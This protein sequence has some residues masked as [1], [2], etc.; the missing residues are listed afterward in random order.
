[1]P[2]SDLNRAG[3]GPTTDRHRILVEWNETVRPAPPATWPDLFAAQVRR[4]PGAVAVVCEDV[5]LTYAQLDARANRLAHALLAR[6]VGPERVVALCLPRSVDMIVAEV[7]VLKAGGAYLPVDQDY[8]AERTGFMLADARPV[9][10]VSTTALASELPATPG[11]PRLLLD[12]LLADEPLAD[13][14]PPTDDRA[15]TR[16]AGTDQAEIDR[17]GGRL[18]DTDP[19]DDDRGA[20]LTPD[21]AAYVI[22]TSGSTG[23]PKGVVVSHAGVAKLVATQRARLGVGPQSRVLQFASPSFDVAFWDLCLGLLSGGRLVVVPAERRVPGPA[24]TEYAHRHGVTFMILPP[25]LLAAMP[26]ELT[27]PAGATLLAGTE[28]V[29]PE[30]VARWARDRPMFNAYG[31]T[32]ATVN[33]TLGECD[34]QT[35]PGGVVPI[36]RPDP[37]TRCYVLD[38]ALQPV[39][40]GA[41]G[42]LYLGGTGL[43][44]GYLG[45]PGLTAQRFVADPYGPAGGRL[46]RTGDLVR[47]LPDGRL[48]FLGRADDQVKIRGYRIE[49]GEI[50]SVLAQHPAVGQVAVLARPGR[51]GQQRLAAYVVPALDRPADR[52]AGVESARV[53]DW[54]RLHELLYTA[55][56]TERFGENFTGWNSSYD[57][58]PIPLAEMREWRDR[59]VERILALR[60]RRVLELGVG[61]GLLLAK[62]APEVESYW[63]TDLSPAAIEALRDEVAAVPALAGRVELRAQPADVTDGLPTGFFDTIVLNSVLQYFPSVDYLAD[64]LRRAV[65]LLAP[66]GSVFVGD[67]RNLRLHRTLRGAIEAGRRRPDADGRPAA[68]AAVEQALSWEGELLLDPEFFPALARE[69]PAIA[70][71]DVEVKRGRAHNELTRYRYDVVL[72]TAATDPST[73]DEA[74]ERPWHDE[75]A[76]LTGLADRLDSARPAV[77]RVTGVPNARLDADLTAYRNL[78]GAP[79]PTAENGAAGAPG[80]DPEAVYELAGRHGYRV[81]VTWS[82]TADDGRLDLLFSHPDAAPATPAY[83][84]EPV[85]GSLD[86]YANRP[87]PFRDV[88]ALLAEL[89]THARSWLPD[90]MV[91]AAFVPLHELPVLPSGKLDRSALP[92]PDFAALT[93]GA[94]PRDAREEVLCALYAE[95][96]GLPEVGVE[97]DFFALGGDSIVSIQLVIRARQAGLVITPRQVFQRRTVAE[98]APVAESLSRAVEDDPQAGVGEFPLTPIMRWLDGCGGRLDAF[99]QW[100]AVRVPAEATAERLAGVLQAA[101]DRHDV[102]RSRLVRATPGQPGRLVVPAPG[103]VPAADLLHRVDVAG[104]TDEALRDRITAA[105]DEAGARLAPEAGAM[106]QA[107]WLDAGR[108]RTGRLVVVVHHVVVDGVSWRILLPDLAAAWPDVAAGR[109]P[110]LEPVGTP[111]RRWAEL[112]I[113]DADSADRTAELPLW[114]ELLRGDDPPLA[115]RPLDPVGDL[116][117]VHRL[118]LRLPADRTAPLLTSIPAAFSAGVNDV[119]LTAFA[120][121]LADWRR[122]R[123]TSVP[124]PALVA[125]EGHGREEQLADGVDLSRTLGWFTSIFP[126]RL[127]PG[128][129]DLADAL[130]GG[131]DA[132]RALKRIKEGLRAI[133]DHGLGY[134]LLRHL[135]PETAAVLAGLP[136]PQISFNYLGRFGVESSPDGC[137]TP[138]PGLGLLA[139]GF[140]AAMPVAPYTLEVNAFTE[141]RPDGPGLGVTWAWPA[142]LLDEADVAELA[143]GW[144]AALDALVRHAARPGAGGPSPSDFPLLPVR[145]DDVDELAATVPAVA[146]LLPL[147]PLQEGLYF[148]AVAAGAD[149]DP[150]RVQQVIELRGPLDAAAL[151]RA[152]QDV[153]D[154]HA[155]LRAAF[156]QL[157]DGRPVQLVA[158][159]ITLPWREVDLT[160]YPEPEREAEFEAL[161]EAE[162]RAP[163]DLARPPL[164][165]CVLV[166][167]D[168]QR[169]DLLLTHHHIVTDGWSAGVTLRDL[170]ARYA[171][172]GEPVRLPAVTPY[173][174]YLDWLAGRDR[175]AA[176]AAWRTA[177]SGVDGP[178]RLAAEAEDGFDGMFHA[179][180]TVVPL[181][182]EVA[183]GLAGRARAAGLTVGSVLHAAWAV[184]LGR[185]L[186]RRDVVFG[187]TVSGRPAELDGVEAMVGLFIN[188]LPVRLRWSPAE[189]LVELAGRLQREQAE[190]LDAQHLGLPAIQRLAGVGELF[191]SLVVVENYPVDAAPGGRAGGLEVA[192]V[193][194]REATHY[195]V[196]LLVAPADD[197]LELTI[198]Y[199]PDRVDA[200]TVRQL[201]TGLAEVLGTFVAEPDRPVG[202]IDLLPAA[203]RGPGLARLTGPVGPVPAETLDGLVAAQAAR[204]PDAVALFDG[205]RQLCYSELDRRAGAL[206]RR[207]AAR[208]VR[209]GDVVAVAVPRSAELVVAMLGVMKTGA[210]YVPLDVSHPRDRLSG[211]LA[212]SGARAVVATVEVLPRV[213]RPDGVAHLLLSPAAEP[214]AESATLAVPSGVAADPDRPAYL[215]YT[216][217]STGRPKGVLVGHRAVVSQLAWSQRRFGIGTE[218]RMLQLAPA[219]FD[220]SVWEIFWP[221]SAGAAV[222][223]PGE[224]E[225]GDPAR[226]AELVRRHRVTAVTFVPSLVE[227]FLLA[228]EVTADPGWAATLRWVSC[229]GEALS[230]DLARR[231]YARTGTALD[232]FYGPTE[233]AVQVTWWA[234]DGTADR[235]VPIGRPVANTRLYVLDDCLRPVPPGVPGELYVAGT[236][237]GYGYHARFGLTAE[238]FVADPYGLAGERM[239]RTGDL[240]RWRT[241]G[242]LEYVGRS[243]AQVKIRGHRIDL[244]EVEAALRSAPGVARAVAAVRVDGRGRSHLVGYLVPVAGTRLDVEAVRAALRAGLPG[245]MVP[246]RFVVLDALPLTPSGKLDRAAL[247]AP[248][249]G[250]EPAA[251]PPAPGAGPTGPVT[252]SVVGPVAG[253]VAGS[254]AGPVAG[255]VVGPVASS[256]IAD[257]VEPAGGGG[258]AERLLREIFAEVLGLPGAGA[259]E[260][261]FALGGDSILSIAVSSRARRHGLALAPRDVFRHRTPRALA[262]A[263]GGDAALSPASAPTASAHAPTATAALTAGSAP[264]SARSLVGSPASPVVASPSPSPS[265]T[266]PDELGDVPLLPTVHW[267]RDT[268][269]PIDRFTLSTLLV[270]PAELD[271]GSLTAVLQAVLDRHAGLRL[272]LRRIA[273]VLWTLDAAPAGAVPAIDLVRRVDVTGLD[274]TGLRTVLAVEAAAATD[275]LAPD[276]GTMLQAVWFD[277]GDR[278][279]RLLLAAHHLVV[280]GVSWRILLEDL[281]AAW[282]SVRAGEPILLAPV[283]TSLRRYARV[284]GEHAHRPERLAELP[285]WAETLAPGAE[286]LPALGRP[287]AGPARQYVV[288]L[289]PAQ[290]LPLLTAVPAAVGGEVTGVLLAALRLAVSR[291][292]DRHGRNAAADLLVDLERHGREEL[293]PG[294]DLSRTVGWFT[295]VQP[296]RLPAGTDPADV[297]RTV[298][299]RIR[300]V[301]DGG[302]GHGLLRYLNAQAA[303]ILAG[304]SSAQ[305]LFHYYGR[306]PGGTG[307]S[308]TPAAESDAV[309]AVNAGLGLSHLLQIDAVATETSAGPVLTATWTW[310]DGTLDEPDVTEL[311][312]EWLDALRTL[313]AA[314]TAEPVT[315]AA[316]DAGRDGGTVRHAPRIAAGMSLSRDEIDRIERTS[317]LPVAEIWPLSPLQ[318]GLYFHASYDTSALD[319]YTA[320]DAFD[321]GYRLDLDRL[322]R[323]GAALLARNP[324]MRAGFT[325]VGLS[326]PVQFVGVAPELPV[327]E[328]DLTDLDPES[329]QV[330]V[331]ELMAEDRATRFDLTR[332]PLCR[333]LLLRLGDDRDR[334][335]VSHHLVLWDGWS[336]ELFVEQLF[337][338]YERDGDD[339]DLPPAG[340][341]RD[342]LEWLAGQDTEQ[343]GRA[344]RDALAGLAEPT[345]VAPE[346]TLAPVVPHR[347]RTELPTV[348]GDRLRDLAR[349]QRLTLNTVLTAAWGLVLGGHLGRTDVV[350]GMTVAGRHGDI[351]HVENIIGLF[352]NTVPVRVDAAPA[353]PVL[354]L[355]RR[356]RDRRIDLMP[357]DHLGLGAVQRATGHARLFDTLYVLQNFVDE[358]E[359][360]RLRDQHGIAAVDGVDATHYPLTLVVTPAERIRVALDHRPDVVPG[361]VARSLLDRFVALLSRLVAEPEI[362]VGR[363]DLLTGAERA[364]LGVE[365][366]A[367]RHPVGTESVADLL[368]E[369]AARTPDEV[370]LVFAG[371]T[372]TY[373]EFDARIN[374]LARLLVDR[375]AGPERV[376]ALAL[377]RSIEMVVALFAV[378]RT[379]AAYLPLELDHPA[380]RLAFVLADTAPMCLLTVAAVRG[381]LPETDTPTVLLDDQLVAAEL[382]GLSGGALPDAELPA[383]F[384]RTDPHRLEYPAYLIYTSG[385]T[386]RPKGVVTPYRGLT[387][388]QLNHREAIFDPTV[389][390]AGGRRLRIAHTVSFAFDMSWEELLW[391]VEGHEVHVCD[392][393]LRRDAQALVAYCDRHRIDVVNVTP[394][395]AHHLIEEG[396]LDQDEAAG[397]SG[398]RHRPVLVLLGGE[399]VSEAVWS[400]LRD[401]EGTAGYNLYGPTEYT[402]NTLGGGTLDSDTPTVGRAIWNTRA[403]VLDAHLRLAPPGAPGELYIGGI[404]LARGYH[405]RLGLT[406]ERFVADPYGAPGERMYRTGDLVR[407]RPDG[408]LDF[409]GR[410]DDQVKIRGYRIELG[411]VE[412]ALA[413]HPLVAHA[414]VV[415]DSSTDPGVRRLAGYVVRGTQWTEPDDDVLTAIRAD[416]KRR[417]PDYM[418]PA[419]L[420]PLDR[421]PLTV[422]GKLD[423]AALPA[424]TV[425]TGAASRPPASTAEKTLCTLFAELLGVPEIGVEDNFFDLGGHSLLAIRLVSRARVALGAE[426]SIRDLFEAPTVAELAAR[427]GGAD[428][429]GTAGDG[430]GR[431]ALVR[432][433]RPAELPLSSAQQ[434]LWMI[435]QLAPESAAYNFPIAVRLR[436]ALDV[437]ALT[438]ALADLTGRHETLRTLIGER[439]GRPYQRVLAVAD[440]RPVLGTV[441]AAP[442]EV[443]GIVRE[444][445]DRPFDLTTEPPLRATLVAVD[446]APGAVEE[447]VLVLVLHHIATDEW[448]DRPFLRDLG[449]AYA[450]RRAGR[451]PDWTPL[452]VQYADYTL[453]Q[454]RLLGEPTDPGSLAARQ[455]DYWRQALDGVP[456]ELVLPTDRPRSG[457]PDPAGAELT[458]ELPAE[459][460]A[461]LRRLARETGTS[462]FMVAHALVAALLH[463]LGA[464]TDIPLGAPIA[465]RGDAALDD[466]V[467]FFVNTLVL[468]TD[469]RGD[470]DF[471]EL[472]ARV[473]RTDLAAFSAQEVPFEAVVEAVNPARSVSRNPLFQVMVVHRNRTA[474]WSGLAGLTV[475]D[476]PVE[477]PAAK[478]DLVFDF[479]EAPEPALP[480]ETAQPALP[481][482]PAEAA[483]LA[484]ARET[485]QP[486]ETGETGETGEGSDGGGGGGGDALS[487]LLKYRTDLFDRETV[488]LL[489][490][491][492]LRLARAVVADPGLPLSRVDVF[493]GDERDRVLREFNATGRQVPEETLPALFARRV[494]ETPEA[495]AV[496][497]RQRTLSYAQ[498]DDE[499]ARMA[500]LLAGHGVGPETVVGVAVPRSAETVAVVLG[501]LRLGAAFLPL[502]F[503]HPADR[504]A[505]M[506]DDSG[507]RIVVTTPE[508]AGRLPE[509]P[510]VSRLLVEPVRAEPVPAEVD[511]GPVAPAGL[512]HAAYVIYTSGSTGRPKGVVVSHEGIASLV[513]TAVDRMGVDSTSRVLQFASTGFDVFVF[514]LAM[515][516]CAGGRLVVAPDEARAPGR[517]LV[518]L[519]ER[520]RVSHAILPPSLVSALPPDCQLPAGLVVLVGTETVPPDLIGRWAQRL[521]LFAAYG[522]T[523]ATVNST[524]W[525]AEPD[526]SGPVPIGLP[527]PNTRAYVLDERLRPVPPGVVGELYV[528]GRGLARGYL[529]RPGLTAERFV[530]DPYAPAGARMYR[531]GDRARWRADG[532]LDFL[533]RVDDQVKIRG[534]RIELGEV[535][536]VLA[537]HPAVRQAAVVVHRNAD[538]TRLAGYVVPADGPVDPAEVRAH[539]AELLPDYMVPAA[540]LVLAGPLPLT[541]NGKL[542]RR[543][544]PAPD[545]AAL[546]GDEAPVTPAQRTLAGLVAEV[547]RLPTVGISDDFFALGGHSMAAMRLLGRIRAALGV[548]LAVR[549]I[550]E[551]PTVAGLAD[552]LAGA[553]ADR[554]ALLRTDEATNPIAAPAQQIWWHLHGGAVERSAAGRTGWDLALAVRAAT[555]SGNTAGAVP[556]NTAATGSGNTAGAGPGNT[557]DSGSG[558]AADAGPGNIADSGW[559]GVRTLDVPA[560]TAALDDLVDRHEPLRTALAVGGAGEPVP[561]TVR[562]TLE[563]LPEDGRPVDERIAELVGGGVDPTRE[564]PLRARLLTGPDGDRVLL[565]T[566]HYLGVDEWSV[567]PLARDLDVAYAARLAG[568][569]PDWS[570]LPVGYPDYARW[571]VTLLGDPADPDSRYA[572]QLDWWRGALSGVPDR[573]ALPTDRARPAGLTGRGGRVE[574]VLDPDSHRAVDELARQTGT[575]MFM[576]FQAALAV[577]LHRVGAGPD[578]PIG[579][580]VAGRTEAALADLVGCF[581]NPLVLRTDTG[582]DPTFTELLGRIRE[583]DLS[584][585]DRQDVP[586]DTVR[587]V[588]PGDRALPQVMLVHHEEARLAG[589]DGSAA[590][591]V[592]PVPTGTTRAELTVSFYEPLGD[593]PVHG[594]LEY[595][596]ELFEPATARRLTDDLLGLL[597][598]AVAHPGLRL[599]ALGPDRADPAPSLPTQSDGTSADHPERT[600]S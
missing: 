157:A 400:R 456:E 11:L 114:T 60:P 2:T 84:P 155:P 440:A 234:N 391:L 496:V 274:D 215:I 294:L 36:G 231:W 247:P 399:A 85:S 551:A 81:A 80:V 469:L 590:L 385:S 244:G 457:R 295:S 185:R 144:F 478:F 12:E 409:L 293:E 578:V 145:Q 141:D 209:P 272:R 573:L 128:P 398:G 280:D 180:R 133:P 266:D 498:L 138:L 514:E 181:A 574:F 522:L 223:L 591:R 250:A 120:L 328:V 246:G 390:A 506:V 101:V 338:L 59:T 19:T 201:R 154:R 322:R 88:T 528:G 39:P 437:A 439:D 380:E 203:E 531:T 502:D 271:L 331:A 190:L 412:A 357:H 383:G 435:Q 341:Y 306:F 376:V 447:H 394:S 86:R 476:E 593:G 211:V 263:A 319:V 261:F 77:L 461:G 54:Q 167:R 259:D 219:S 210:A 510:G 411:E 183:A 172:G 15:G 318:E 582:G 262:E 213:P 95:V 216:S 499:A 117:S 78:S 186:G 99:A 305:V 519:L 258:A 563:V 46:Y 489:G 351:P 311:A 538:L 168:A 387:N 45:Q 283:G 33:S 389:A 254:V 589:P 472:L 302:L 597:A 542:D 397:E 515:A 371:R 320:Q 436:G 30:L 31:P 374:R 98:L 82:G 458:V 40:V 125:L 433:E 273:S 554:P 119:L 386:G 4:A 161:A 169:H 5:E 50:E 104:L 381:G 286:L 395:Y 233:T 194:F 28:R 512:D 373:A 34:P 275:R 595:A 495:V 121:A 413:E 467:G 339:R 312:A 111:L 110:R 236:Q 537:R 410:T 240:V 375:G 87:A 330:R 485:V 442:A 150:Y 158:D 285:H 124:G 131:E 470:P 290:T 355:L 337:T 525:R 492:L 384:A 300:A 253:S 594:E 308:W 354:G 278:P 207:L 260:D 7:A 415:V 324:G 74:V 382:A 581:V 479:A 309:T 251:A 160:G 162:R 129:I 51:D 546:T 304:L 241:D 414:A 314:V 315:D 152:G 3:H 202:R 407:R 471:T 550:F 326:Q 173:R 24:L 418:V 367:T 329:Q 267:L 422:N 116:D 196:T 282:A 205:E 17:P 166:R 408:N 187:S 70:R 25:A 288:R 38:D 460:G 41:T 245:S 55:G 42:E 450:A 325:S 421:L 459:V 477:T 75:P 516:L 424:P 252:R 363:L 224:D 303:P 171:P 548:D 396:L 344:W 192:G 21:S 68:L 441:V 483:Q 403:Y 142:A 571:A 420:V 20:P 108:D 482:Q 313:A 586:F 327:T 256:S 576:V 419:A 364:E 526:W 366:S 543:A 580:L 239:Y 49:P 48:E 348:L 561:V 296:V 453:W 365:W 464:G 226:L 564:P 146:D 115:D 377:P 248:A 102:L 431:I 579:T 178:T 29:S 14:Q 432:A 343:A 232:N 284:L 559:G 356:L 445:V 62:V 292:Q 177:L 143:D 72:R 584:A 340:S 321:L 238:R 368:A 148:H 198:E 230:P 335:V 427:I 123:G 462:L 57:G 480:A 135:N 558:N 402:I 491:R 350:F 451:A 583:A 6:G 242:V 474:E 481:A 265:E 176:D 65:A 599:S 486:A 524:L 204:T 567:V 353:E 270:V 193:E 134:G 18:P 299:E 47:W 572:R 547:L 541:A 105:A 71:V 83:R 127:D 9:C 149:R 222:V 10:L 517:P 401:T 577:L 43:A 188:T 277:S 501:A 310:P 26:R 555:G 475:T 276:E 323:A 235:T 465:G 61:S 534:F 139:G 552:R 122:R 93:T 130:A 392:E 487:C 106:L 229:G 488:A 490:E 500:R 484:Q 32:E 52:D 423:V 174:R 405:R 317:P 428:Q 179:E 268:G 112:A 184:L 249:V 200:A 69:V 473:R 585:F 592:E 79:A 545:W 600:S 379:G 212:D 533:G 588:L 378:L 497:D 56:R 332:P 404:G 532:I 206:A 505:F 463:R 359:S 557:A 540:V 520:E 393:E 527:D 349:R 243:D 345:L 388:M 416:L 53:D 163:F 361:A 452:P 347:V 521:R 220:T 370:A 140:D 513:A 434:R 159:R 417:L 109:T 1:M 208:G 170:L 358:G 156:P 446:G 333:L 228:D 22:Y 76:G 523:E 493:V 225:A 316:V 96:L 257:G 298:G 218:D 136:Q 100:L 566:V 67:V 217:G 63:G 137:W 126:V 227:A 97:D 73:V 372:L 536:A 264:T 507:A 575:S 90:H 151:R 16:Q 91:P 118:T 237:L 8:P 164:L 291:W 132:G 508:A 544:L 153:L 165:R 94:R 448:S 468:R 191:D 503:G 287:P 147:T 92:A 454:R 494:A 504:L 342:H 189:P 44:R 362:A 89:R 289:E 107:V 426:L 37:G 199:D 27:L 406:A 539:A 443:A 301:P 535:E 13:A 568:R 103:T 596:V 455:L 35:P 182:P 360:A 511:P 221:L 352:L 334:L 449:A 64:V 255:S 214:D 570:P 197:L 466:L 425:R 307:E 518:D 369:Q 569:A 444:A 195:P 175:S 549:D 113:A 560:L 553:V 336:E 23:R 346:A 587:R 562:P 529:G 556:G 429:D 565:L 58:L 438:S 269:L 66:G 530:A 430:G 297:L 281:A 598:S 279:G 509:L